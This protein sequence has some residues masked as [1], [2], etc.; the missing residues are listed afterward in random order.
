MVATKAHDKRWMLTI[1]PDCTRA[2]CLLL[3]HLTQLAD[4]AEVLGRVV[5]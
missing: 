5:L 2:V 1:P 3:N 4:L